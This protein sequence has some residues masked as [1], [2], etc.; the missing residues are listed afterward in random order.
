MNTDKIKFKLNLEEENKGFSYFL[1][2]LFVGLLISSIALTAFSGADESTESEMIAAQWAKAELQS[3]D[4]MKYILLSERDR[5]K[6][7]EEYP[8]KVKKEEAVYEFDEYDLFQWK[9]SKNDYIYKFHY[10][11]MK[12]CSDCK[13][14]VWV[15]VKYREGEWIVPD[16]EFNELKAAPLIKNLEAEQ[17]PTTLEQEEE[18]EKKKPVWKKILNL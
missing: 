4:S 6:F 14:D 5:T 18:L 2:L 15:R 9:R 1:I 12:S 7:M 13:K 16:F 8:S 17:I 11:G 10:Y 3:N